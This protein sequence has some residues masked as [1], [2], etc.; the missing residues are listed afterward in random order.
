MPLPPPP[1]SRVR[2]NDAAE[3]KDAQLG[4]SRAALWDLVHAHA[5]LRALERRRAS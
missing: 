4:L 5:A 3:K 2:E 1:L